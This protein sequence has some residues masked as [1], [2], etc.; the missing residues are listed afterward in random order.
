[1]KQKIEQLFS[2]IFF[3]L[4]LTDEQAKTL[5]KHEQE[6]IKE[7]EKQALNIPV[8][9]QQR[10]L[11]MAFEEWRRLQGFFANATATFKIV[12]EYLESH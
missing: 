3:D 2:D 4:D 12:D 1:M 6:L 9:S 7:A 10:E 5:H 11:L 8:V